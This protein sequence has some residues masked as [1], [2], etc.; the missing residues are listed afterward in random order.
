VGTK[1]RG[2]AS[3]LVRVLA[4]LP[5]GL[6]LLGADP[7]VPVGERG[8]SRASLRFGFGIGGFVRCAR[9]T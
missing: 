7:L 4:D 2:A 3:V 5:V 6:A 9:R 8:A 1:D